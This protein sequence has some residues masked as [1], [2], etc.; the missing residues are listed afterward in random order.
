MIRLIKILS[1]LITI[2]ISVDLAV[3]A[4]SAVPKVAPFSVNPENEKLLEKLDS[5]LANSDHFVAEKE[6]R[7]KR[8]RENYLSNT[9]L[10]RRYWLASELYDE[11]SAYDS[12]SAL[13]YADRALDFATR[14]GR[15]DL[16]SEMQLNRSYLFS[17]TG[18][19]AQADACLRQINPD[20]LPPHLFMKYCDR[21]LFLS[22][23]QDQYIGVKYETG[24]FSQKVDSLIQSM[25]RSITPDD[26]HYCWLVGW[27]SLNDREKARKAIP[28][29]EKVVNSTDYST[30]GNAMDAW[31]LSKLY[32]Q[33]GDEGNHFKYLVLSAIADVRASNKEIA[34]L[35]ELAQILYDSGDLDRANSYIN[36]SIAYANEYKSRVR[37]GKLAHLQEQ[38]L[39]AIQERHEHQA[40]SNHWYLAVL[41]VILCIL[42]GAFFYIMRQYRLLKKSRETLNEANGELSRKVEELQTI[43]EELNSANCKLSEMYKT[44]AGYSRRLAEVND[45][46]ESCIAN[47]FAI[48]SNYINKLEDFRTD[49]SRLLANR[50]FEKAMTMVKSPELS[51]AEVKQL[52]ASFDEIFLQI[53]PDFVKDFNSLLRPEERIEL[54][55]PSRLNTELRI[56]AL[57]RLGMNDSVSIAK[58]LHC[59]V[60]TVYNTRHRTRNKGIVPTEDFAQAVMDLGKRKTD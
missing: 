47:L 54:K 52:Y 25:S 8:L 36:H 35:E 4:E 17:A 27:S 32:E 58:F 46:K 50:Q 34:S 42:V 37:L 29:V 30:R 53:Y 28:L 40:K 31:V 20:S 12:D 26:P 23:H 6:E 57:V 9:S 10:E 33:A 55:N 51:Y 48:C 21:V 56:Y 16:A 41:I 11:Y 13:S 38:I 59:S 49:I 19:F 39:G 60:Q 18:L 1:F 15:K 45:E 24:V 7:I 22:T 14:L 3:G 44:E 2:S 5:L 43:R